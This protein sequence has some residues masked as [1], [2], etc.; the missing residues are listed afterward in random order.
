MKND[1]LQPKKNLKLVKE[2]GTC[3]K[4]TFVN[5]HLEKKVETQL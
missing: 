4:E 5:G 2:F 3:W 1:V